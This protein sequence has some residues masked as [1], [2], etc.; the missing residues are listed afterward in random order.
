MADAPRDLTYESFRLDEVR[1]RVYGDSAV[2]I[3]H[4]VSKGAYQGNPV[5]GHLRVTLVLVKPSGAWRLANAPM[6]FIAGT[7]GA[8]TIHGLTPHKRDS[9]RQLD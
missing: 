4:Q 7:P 8:P 6:S 5:P 9:E 1:V 2:V 3:A